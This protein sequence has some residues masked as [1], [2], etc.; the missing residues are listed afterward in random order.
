MRKHRQDGPAVPGG[1]TADLVLIQAGEF[2]A[3]LEGLLDRPAASGHPRQDVQWDRAG[4]AG[5]VERALA[6]AGAP[7]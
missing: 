5:A 2:L 3:G 4:G 1:A 6:G 7:R